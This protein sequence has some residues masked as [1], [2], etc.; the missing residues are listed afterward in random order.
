[1]GDTG[2]EPVTSS[3]WRG[4]SLKVDD[5]SFPVGDELLRVRVV[6]LRRRTM[7]RL[8]RWVKATYG[9]DV[10]AVGGQEFLTIYRAVPRE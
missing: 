6:G 2:F 10:V 8:L 1:V 4:R 9:D 7:R 5:S 3:L